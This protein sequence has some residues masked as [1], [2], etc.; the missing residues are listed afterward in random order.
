MVQSRPRAGQREETDGRWKSLIS[1]DRTVE[2]WRFLARR[3]V[4]R[5][6]IRP[7]KYL[8]RERAGKVAIPAVEGFV[9]EQ[10]SVSEQ[11]VSQQSVSSGSLARHHEGRGAWVLTA[12]GVSGLALFGILAYFFSEFI[13]H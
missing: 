10:S 12:Y 9:E 5:S 1:G 13:A 7:Q 8:L 6:R 4:N 3:S 2:A 11:S